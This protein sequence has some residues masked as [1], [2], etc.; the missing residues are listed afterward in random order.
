MI[1]RTT[2]VVAAIAGLTPATGASARTT[3]DETAAPHRVT[4]RHRVAH[5][6]NPATQTDVPQEQAPPQDDAAEPVDVPESVYHASGSDG[7]HVGE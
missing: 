4:H 5:Y 6:R 1:T 2:I 7:S 3:T